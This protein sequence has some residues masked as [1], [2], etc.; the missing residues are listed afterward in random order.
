MS[1]P[2]LAEN[3]VVHHHD[4]IIGRSDLI[5]EVHGWM[6]PVAKFTVKRTG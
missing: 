4:G 6:N 5:P 1:D 2:A 3:G